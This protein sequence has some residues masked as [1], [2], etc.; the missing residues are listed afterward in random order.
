MKDLDT[1]NLKDCQESLC[2]ALQPQ[3]LRSSLSAR[4]ICDR[5]Q[6]RKA[7]LWRLGCKPRAEPKPQSEP[8]LTN[9]REEVVRFATNTP[10]LLGGWKVPAAKHNDIVALKLLV[11]F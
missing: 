10:L 6:A 3:I 5:L 1:I 8:D 2:H 9:R 11:K 7:S 4:S